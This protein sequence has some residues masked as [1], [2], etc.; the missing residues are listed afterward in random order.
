M[1]NQYAV[2]RLLQK[3]KSS[4][5]GR[6]ILKDKPRLCD[7]NLSEIARFAPGSLGQRYL[8]FYAENNIESNVR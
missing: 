6:R 5:S 3:M 1:T 2:E 8:D 4:E 7:I